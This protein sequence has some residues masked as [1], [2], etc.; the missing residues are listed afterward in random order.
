M[1]GY[2][3][4]ACLT[5]LQEVLE[6][7]YTVDDQGYLKVVNKEKQN[8]YDKKLEQAIQSDKQYLIDIS[9]TCYTVDQLT[10]EIGPYLY[11]ELDPYQTYHYLQDSNRM[12]IFLTENAGHKLTNT[13]II[14]SVID[15]I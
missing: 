11:S 4:T 2:G 7:T 8:Q 14:H 1:R 9:S 3:R 10:G 13:E 12:V 6:S 15:L 5:M